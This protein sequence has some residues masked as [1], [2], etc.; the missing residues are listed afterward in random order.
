M[1]LK[2]VIFP[3]KQ[4]GDILGAGHVNDLSDHVQRVSSGL[5]GSFNMGDGNNTSNFA[6]FIQIPVVVITE[7]CE[8]DADLYEVQPLY[9]DFDTNE[10]KT[11]ETGTRYCLDPTAFDL[12]FSVDDRLVA[13]WYPQRSMFLP[14]VSSGCTE[15]HFTIISANCGLKTA[16]VQ[17]DSR[18]CG[19]SKAPEE[20]SYGQLTVHDSM[21]CHLDEPNADLI[22]RKGAATYMQLNDEYDTCQWEIDD[23]CCDP[24]ICVP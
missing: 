12:T 5:G 9:Y 6:P 15:I 21:G 22:D 2:K 23:I 8:G 14:F 16:L 19:C 11:N 7:G 10:W 3:K 4:E 1:A 13:W 18:T 20:D 24:D 17:I